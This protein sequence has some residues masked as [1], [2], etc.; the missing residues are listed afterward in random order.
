MIRLSGTVFKH[1]RHRK[2]KNKTAVEAKVLGSLCNMFQFQLFVNQKS[3]DYCK[4][5]L[6]IDRIKRDVITAQNVKFSIKNF[7][8][9]CNHTY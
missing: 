5:M 4:I 8:S 3:V 7:F 6:L 1:F 2:S 9:K